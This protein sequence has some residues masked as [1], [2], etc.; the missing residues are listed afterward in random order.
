MSFAPQTQPLWPAVPLPQPP[1]PQPPAVNARKKHDAKKDQER[2]VGAAVLKGGP[3]PPPPAAGPAQSPVRGTTTQVA[4]LIPQYAGGDQKLDRLGKIVAGIESS[5]G[6]NPVT[7]SAG[8]MGVM[9]ITPDT[10]RTYGLDPSRL[11][12]QAYNVAGGMK[13]LKDLLQ[14]SGG[15][16][17]KAAIGY[18][19]GPGNMATP[20]AALS[21][22]TQAYAQ[23]IAAS[24]SPPGKPGS[25]TI[26]PDSG[27]A[28]GNGV[29]PP[30]AQRPNPVPGASPQ[31][32]TSDQLPQLAAPPPANR[33][34]VPPFTPAQYKAPNKGLEYLALGIGLLF[35]G[36]PI[37]RLAAGFAGGLGE[38]AQQSYQRR[39]QQAEQQYKTTQAQALADSQNAEAERTAKIE[40]QKV[41]FENAKMLYEQHQQ[42]RAGGIDPKTGRPFVVPPGLQRVLPPGQ[43]RA[44]TAGDYANH[45]A[46]LAQ[47]Y[48][49]VGATDI[50]KQHMTA[51]QDYHKQ[52]IDDANNARALAIAMYSQQ[53]QNARETSR[54]NAA[55]G[56][57]ASR[58]DAADAR[59]ARR[60]AHE[61]ARAL[62]ADG[63]KRSALQEQS[64][65]AGQ[66]FYTAWAKALKA[67]LD[68]NGNPRVNADGTPLPAIISPQMAQT[69]SKM[70][71]M[72]D[73]DSD[74]GG[75][76]QHYAS[77][78]PNLKP[79]E[80]ELILA[81]GRAADPTRRAK[82]LPILPHSYAKKPAG[83]GPLGVSGGSGAGG[84]ADAKVQEAVEKARAIPKEQRTQLFLSSDSAK[85]MNPQQQQQAIQQMNAL[86]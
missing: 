52:V 76:A 12:D 65:K 83:S 26:P 35:P 40:A 33:E 57:E 20:M 81:R 49:S 27:I 15:D 59:D 31:N 71:S 5:G 46:Q 69:L 2:K 64:L 84:G 36:A 18:N 78:A 23:R 55:A 72:I 58:E 25:A 80:K 73:R 1:T 68:S 41:A 39:E 14:K 67:P 43:N 37:S 60:L 77:S 47:F 17:V 34:S 6:R 48:T 42:V 32:S 28:W 7:S 8:A 61:D 79:E 85:A 56:R 44:A 53:N 21:P 74:P 22:E 11:N 38:G 30:P 66:E 9:Q 70:F 16:P 13:I 51:A 3:P 62:M 29:K 19:A 10:A 86:P 4:A 54:E 24:F 50:A 45:E 82:G 75:T 63:T